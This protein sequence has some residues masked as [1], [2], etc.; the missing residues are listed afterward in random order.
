M[1]KLLVSELCVRRCR[2]IET[3]S[4]H[5]LTGAYV[6]KRSANVG[7]LDNSVIGKLEISNRKDRKFE[8]FQTAFSALPSRPS[9]LWLPTGGGGGGGGYSDI[10][11]HA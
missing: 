10:F 4:N 1:L 8:I 5:A 11:I 2:H 9:R 7:A 6:S 3:Q